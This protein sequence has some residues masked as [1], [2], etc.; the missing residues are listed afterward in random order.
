M[1]TY[2]EYFIAIATVMTLVACV[3]WWCWWILF[4]PSGVDR[5]N[6]SF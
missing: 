5:R 2:I 3:A 1:S 6:E 4:V